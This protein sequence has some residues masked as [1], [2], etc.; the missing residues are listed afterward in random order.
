MTIR[1]KLVN[2]SGGQPLAYA[3]ISVVDAEGNPTG[4][5]TT[6]GTDGV[7]QMYT[8]GD[9]VL[10]TYTGFQPMLF[11]TEQLS[12]GNVPV[13]GLNAS[14]D[15]APVTVTAHKKTNWLPWAVAAAIAYYAFK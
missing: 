11:E 6:A 9:Y 8:S 12:F 3:S 14:G 13:I 2:S 15:L 5:G 4:E 10:F 7:F 1:G